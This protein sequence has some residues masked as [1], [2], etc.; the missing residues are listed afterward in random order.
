VDGIVPHAEA[1]VG[2]LSG[3]GTVQ[4]GD[5]KLTV[6]VTRQDATQVE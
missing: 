5:E 3:W 1:V 2:E 4:G 6:I